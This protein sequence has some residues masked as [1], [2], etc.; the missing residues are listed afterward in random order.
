MGFQHKGRTVTADK[1]YA[2]TDVESLRQV[3][4]RLVKV[5]RPARTSGK[6]S[7]A[8]ELVD[9]TLD[10]QLEGDFG[11]VYTDADNQSCVATDTMKNTVYAFARQDPIAHV[12]SFCI[13]LADHF[14]TK[15]G[16][17]RVRISAQR[18]SMGT[19]HRRRRCRTRTRSSSP[20]TSSGR[21]S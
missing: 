20:A 7:G 16:V 12:E 21:R 19:G 1:P 9:L 2:P 5:R 8:H 11:A 15:P 6:E 13:A 17:T 3:R 18:T 14:A 4:I 10:I